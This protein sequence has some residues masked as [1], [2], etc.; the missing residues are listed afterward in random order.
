M[1]SRSGRAGN[2]DDILHSPAELARRFVHWAEELQA[3]PGILWGCPALDRILIPLRAG[4]LAAVI[5]RPGHGKTS[6]MA[7]IARRQAEEIASA[8]RADMAVVYVTW[9]QAA[10]EMES[11]FQA[12]GAFSASDIA[13]GRV[14]LEVVRRRSVSRA[15]LPIWVIGYSAVLAATGRRPVDVTLERVLHAIQQMQ[16]DYGVR[17]ALLLFDYVQIIP[18]HGYQERRERVAEMPPMIKHLAMQIGA[19]AIIGVQARR[20]VDDYVLKIPGLS[21][22]QWSSAIEQASDVVLGLWRPAL[23]ENPGSMVRIGGRYYE[24][25]QSLFVLRVL[26]QR[27]GIGRATLVLSF[28]PQYLDLEMLPEGSGITVGSDD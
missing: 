15:S 6:F 12:S 23:T 1:S 25:G 7:T 14:D 10:E 3:D 24:V 26:K 5:A 9:E 13:A 18:A 21:D 28:R 27:G 22:A 11:F 4:R 19:P 17:P 20:E 16:A 8:G 2:N